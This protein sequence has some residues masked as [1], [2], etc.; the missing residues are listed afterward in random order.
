MPIVTTNFIK[1]RMNKSVDERLLPPGEYVDAMNLRLGA[2]ETTE[3]G[4][5]ENSK[6]NTQL[7][8]LSFPE[9]TPLSSNTRCLGA[10][11]DHANE[12]LYWFVHDP[13]NTTL[14]NLDAVISYNTN[15]NSLRY[16]VIT[17]NTL[18]FNPDYLITGVEKIEDLLFFTDNINPPRKINITHN[19]PF[20]VAGVDQTIEEDLNV[21]VKPPGYEFDPATTPAADVPLPAPQLR[22]LTLPGSENYIEDRFLCFAYRYRYA[23][24]E[25]SAISLF[26]KP[27]FATSNFVFNIK[28]Y[29]NDGMK[30]RFNAV[31]VTFNTGSKRVKEVDLL[32]KDTSNNNVYVIERFN[33]EENGWANDARRTF[34]F[35]NSK[36][37]SVLGSDEILRLYDNVPKYAKALTLMGNRLIYGNYTDGYNIT[38]SSNQKIAL[39]YSTSLVS[40]N[41]DFVDL[42]APTL[43]N[44]DNYTIDPNNTVTATNAVAEFNL[45]EITAQ[46]KR[47]SILNFSVLLEHS[48]LSGTV[49]TDCYL[50]NNTFTNGTLEISFSVVLE[51]DYNSVYDFSQ[52]SEFRNAVGTEINVN[53]QPIATASQGG[54]LTDKFNNDLALPSITCTFTKALSG[55][56]D[57]VA[58]QPFRI[59]ATP[60]SDVIK[61]Q[62]IAMKFTSSDLS[63]TTDLYE[64]FRISSAEVVFSSLS[65]TG[66]LHSNRD[67]QTGIV[68]LD[69]YGRASTV[70]TSNFNTVSI[71]AAN[72]ISVN[73]IKTTINNYAP[74]WAERYKFVVKPSKSNY[75]TIFSNFYYTVQSSQVTYFK[76]EGDNQNKVKTGDTLIVKTDVSGATSSVIKAKVLNVEAQARDFLNDAQ[77]M[78]EDTKQLPG[79]Y[80]EIKPQNFNVNIPSD[81][82]IENGLKTYEST[83]DDGRCRG[84]VNYPAFTSDDS[85]N[86]ATTENYTIPAGSAIE[87]NIEVYRSARGSKC[88]GMRWEWK[89]VLYASQ[90]YPDLRRWWIGDQINPGNASPGTLESEGG[91]FTVVYNTNVGSY[92]AGAGAVPCTTTGGQ[93]I[94]D[95]SVIFQFLQDTP[96]DASSPLGL[97]VKTKKPGCAG[98]QPFSR[99]RNINVKAEITVTRANTM[100]VFETEPLDANEG[101]F[102]DASE[103]YVVKLDSATGNYLHM[104]GGDTGDQDQTSTNPATVTLPFIDCFTFAN[105]VES[106]KINDDFAGRALTMGQRVLAVSQQ[107]FKE[108]HRF[109]D[110]TYS[111]IFS[112][113]AGVNNL[114]EFNLGLANFKEL[115][116]SFGPVQKLYARETDILTL[117]EDRISYVL[118]SKNLISDATGGGP[119][120]SSPTILGTQIART[121]EYGISFNPESFGA[122]G[123][124]YYFTDTKRVAVIRLIGNN[125]NDQLQVISDLGMRSWFRDNFQLALETQKLGGYDPYM[126]EY[127]LS[128]NNI[129]VPVPPVVY[130]CGSEFQ[131]LKSSTAVS[132]NINFGETIG[133]I[134]VDYTVTSGT[135]DVSIT[136]NGN[137]VSSGNVTTDGSVTIAKTS[138]S[139]NTA[140]VTVTPTGTSTFSVT[141]VCVPE[142]TITVFKC[143]INSNINSGSL[144]HVEYGWSDSTTI[145]PIDTDQITMGSNDLVFSSFEG[146]TGVRSQGVYPYN[147]ASLNMRVNKLATDDYD[148]KYPNDNFK[149]LSSNTLYANTTADV[150]TLLAAASE[151]PNASVTNPTGTVIQQA[152]VDPTTTP[153]FTLPTAN[154]YLY[155]IYDFRFTSAQKLCYS[156]LA[157]EACCDCVI[158]CNPFDASTRQGTKN[159]A[160]QQPLTQEFYYAGSGGLA[161][162]DIV[163]SDAQ[164]AGNAPGQNVNT[165]TA[166]YYK[167]TGNEYIRVNEFGIVIEKTTC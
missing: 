129:T 90:E 4:A 5:I 73:K 48:T 101:I 62:T 128:T 120:V 153:P 105:G 26:S 67:F 29:N 55:I 118:A 119:I 106:F 103:S 98:L 97:A 166:G 144:I 3:I 64:Y 44:G 81:S 83:G 114:N 89:Q 152:T 143:V 20:P 123:D 38:N 32:F 133:D 17:K 53:F 125:Q 117:Q 87:F 163:Y 95:N 2:T 84:G 88:D 40:K 10:Y 135:I 134:V 69:S 91:D 139:P 165:L 60:G 8:S 121:E 24:N 23:N 77:G 158:P 63:Q 93:A 41:V 92:S 70:L 142:Q 82:V 65:D 110:L 47:N 56:D 35:N 157:S 19:Y 122:Y 43:S 36:V 137:T 45:S 108:A 39:D 16:H 50:A 109:A 159:I 164:C 99:R 28:N 11:E 57:S 72:S 100:V 33:K 27:A 146:Q 80:M 51:N 85:T 74:S 162:Y 107:D 155:L 104:S 18:N 49:N 96:G 61:L 167:I 154:Q 15:G 7:T 112:S 115:E 156:T 94:Q 145:S 13:N 1:G 21:I 140:L 126:D 124:S 68:Y 76:L 30:N 102:Y 160:C 66:S 59:T 75:E 141:P 9:G 150:A 147:G 52:S 37:Y 149:F 71:P 34:Q 116:T 6:G 136:W 86:P 130:E 132:Y 138:T 148:W 79:L 127:V 131:T 25:Y 14:G 161:L 151:I 42:Q 22:G 113:N 58:Q 78:G 12:T 46:L 111:G 54:S 31:N